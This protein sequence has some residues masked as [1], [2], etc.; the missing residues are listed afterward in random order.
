MANIASCNSRGDVCD[1]LYPHFYKDGT[2]RREGNEVAFLTM[3]ALYHLN[4][5]D[6][7]HN[8]I[9][10]KLVLYFDNFPGQNKN[11]MV[12]RLAMYLVEMNI[13]ESVIIFFL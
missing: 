5:M 13:F 6:F 4:W 3:K 7:Q 11:G 10:K 12:I 9:G 2:A 1:H 8:G